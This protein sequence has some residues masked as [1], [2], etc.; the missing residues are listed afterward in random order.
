MLGIALNNHSQKAEHSSKEAERSWLTVLIIGLVLALLIGALLSVVLNPELLHTITDMISTA[1]SALR[2]VSKEILNAIT[3]PFH[4]RQSNLPNTNIP[5]IDS[6]KVSQS[7]E[8]VNQLAETL[9]PIVSVVG[10]FVI[11][12][13][14][15]LGL[16]K[17]FLDFLEL[18]SRLR[19]PANASIEHASEGWELELRAFLDLLGELPTV[20]H[21][22]FGWL[23]SRGNRAIAKDEP[24][25]VGEMRNTYRELLKLTAQ[26]G[27]RRKKQETPHEFLRRAS[28]MLPAA[29]SD[30]R[31]LTEHY[32]LARYYPQCLTE[33]DCQAARASW[34]RLRKQLRWWRAPAPNVPAKKLVA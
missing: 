14:V 16:L 32:V 19:A 29:E 33:N 27:L 1:V 3:G 2:D 7:D 9:G 15:G 10:I 24:P 4:P 11:V 5:I 20:P 26:R 28:A 21:A 31:V 22:L 12:L 34:H 18:L 13:V 6:T 25:Q 8:G 17:Y 30:L 23:R